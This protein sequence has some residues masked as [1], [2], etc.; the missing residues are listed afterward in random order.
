[1]YTS[2]LTAL[3]L[4]DSLLDLLIASLHA[5]NAISDLQVC[6]TREQCHGLCRHA[7]IIAGRQ[8]LDIRLDL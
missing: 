7:L 4:I 3:K 6:P 2:R 5:G 8:W 1:L